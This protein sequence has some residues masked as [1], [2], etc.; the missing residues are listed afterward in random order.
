LRASQR[1]VEGRDISVLPADELTALP[2][3]IVAPLDPVK[4]GAANRAL[5]RAGIPWRYGSRRTENASARGPA[6][7]DE[8]SVASRYDL[9][10]QPGAVAETLAVVG[11]DAWIVAGPRYVIVGSPLDPQAT[12][13]PVRASFVP[14]LA[15][16]LTERLVGE[17]G[18][19]VVAAPGTRIPRP[20]WADAMEGGSADGGRTTLGDMVDVP[21]RAGTYFLTRGDRRV[22]ALVVNAPPEE[23]VLDRYTVQQLPSRLRSE[24]VITAP[25]QNDWAGMAF[26]SAA[27]KSLVDPMLIA[28]LIFLA[29]EAVVI[30]ARWRRVA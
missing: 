8:V 25:D 4:I 7:G 15:S 28:A 5:E 22:G 21:I 23:S 24:R 20:A 17:P 14:W 2:A 16:V 1:I 29:V 10:A 27:R 19:V 9:V 6:L 18:Q 12:S 30:G 3:L 13:L 11:R 26:R